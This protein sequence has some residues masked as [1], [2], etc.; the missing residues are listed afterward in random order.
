MLMYEPAPSEKS[1][2]ISFRFSV[3]MVVVAR[4]GVHFTIYS[5]GGGLCRPQRAST[6]RAPRLTFSFQESSL[7]V[8]VDLM[9]G[10]IE[11]I[12]FELAVVFCA[13][14]E[15]ADDDLT[16]GRRQK[17]H[18]PIERRVAIWE[19]INAHRCIFDQSRGMFKGA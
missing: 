1:R 2:K 8:F 7:V 12:P 10:P 13:L 15:I 16:K 18:T 4:S 11:A 14:A 6:M 3:S 9:A 5:W 19:R 17:D